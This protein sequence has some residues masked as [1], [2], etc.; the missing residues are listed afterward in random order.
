[1]TDIEFFQPNY[2]GRELYNARSELQLDADRLSGIMAHTRGESGPASMKATVAN[3]LNTNVNV[4]LN[5]TANEIIDKVLRTL[6]NDF[7]YAVANDPE[8]VKVTPD[9][10]QAIKEIINRGFV[11]MVP[12]PEA[13][14]G[15]QTAKQQQLMNTLQI[16]L[17]TGML[18]PPG[19]API[20][21]DILNLSGMRDPE[22][23]TRHLAQFMPEQVQAGQQALSGQRSDGDALAL[24]GQQATG[25]PMTQDLAQGMAPGQPMLPPGV[26]Q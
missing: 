20:L 8:P 17:P 13:Y 22:E 12:H 1:M 26:Q 2:H 21:R 4:R 25:I 24:G 16:I 5:A 18:Q 3:M 10:W 6:T 19:I 15:N 23:V 9:E 11:E 14:V 7:M